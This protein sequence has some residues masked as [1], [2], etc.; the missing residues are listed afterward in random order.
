MSTKAQVVA[1]WTIIL[2]MAQG[3]ASGDL[4]DLF[5]TIGSPTYSGK[6]PGYGWRLIGIALFAI[7]LILLSEWNDD[8][9]NMSMLFL[10]GLTLVFLVNNQALVSSWIGKVTS[11]VPPGSYSPG[12]TTGTGKGK[13]KSGTF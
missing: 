9:A 3:F 1:T 7:M 11:I 5:G 13:P 12:G 6:H 4:T 8:G 2:A 10:L